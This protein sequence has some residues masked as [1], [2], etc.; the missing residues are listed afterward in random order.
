MRRTPGQ[1]GRTGV[2]PDEQ[3]RKRSFYLSDADYR[4]LEA[5]A[6]QHPIH[7]VSPLVR[8]IVVQWLNRWERE[9]QQEEE[10]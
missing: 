8:W 7:E 4:R 6:E 10:I 1:P 2:L 3:A 9:Q 5:A